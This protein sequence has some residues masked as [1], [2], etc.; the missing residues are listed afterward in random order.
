MPAWS[1]R[2]SWQSSMTCPMYSLGVTIEALMNG[3]RIS[4]MRT[5]SGMSLGAWTSSSS[6]LVSVTS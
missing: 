5:G 3:S 4:S 6:P 2:R 1:P